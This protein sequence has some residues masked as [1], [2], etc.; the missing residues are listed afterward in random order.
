MQL[1]VVMH[2]QYQH[3]YEGHKKKQMALDLQKSDTT[4]RNQYVEVKLNAHK[5]CVLPFSKNC[6]ESL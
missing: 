4:K 1:V 5:T 3:S 6:I 2:A